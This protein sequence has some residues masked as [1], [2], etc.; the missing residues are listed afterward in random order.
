MAKNCFLCGTKLALFD[1]AGWV[2]MVTSPV[3][4]YDTCVQCEKKWYDSG[5]FEHLTK[6][7]EPKEVFRIGEVEYQPILD[8]R[9][10]KGP[11]IFFENAMLYLATWEKSTS[12]PFGGVIAAFGGVVSCFGSS[13]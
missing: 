9:K 13:E 3:P 10:F 6:N 11:L 2:R 1:A 12:K 8:E 5:I 7:G 4:E